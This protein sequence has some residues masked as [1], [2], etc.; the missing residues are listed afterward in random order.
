MMKM[1]NYVAL[2]LQDVVQQL[3]PLTV[4]VGTCWLVYS[5][6]IKKENG[7]DTVTFT[8]NI[9]GTMNLTNTQFVL[10]NRTT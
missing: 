9:A 8:S 5:E 2:L 3:H 7:A 10:H 1:K 4:R 6:N